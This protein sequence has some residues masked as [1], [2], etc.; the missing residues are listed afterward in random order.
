[1]VTAC[2]TAESDPRG[3]LGA[4]VTL[5]DPSLQDAKAELLAT[6]IEE[7]ERLNRFIANLLDMTR[8]EAGAV[9]E[10]QGPLLGRIPEGLEY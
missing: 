7:S 1:M 5:S 6:I 9:A 10:T 8:L 2:A 4:A 3:D